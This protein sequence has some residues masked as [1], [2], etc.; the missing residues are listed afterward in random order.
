[1]YAKARRAE[2]KGFTGIDD[3]YEPP[4][5]PEITLDTVA[6]T[7]QENTR[8]I[9][10]YLVEQGFLKEDVAAGSDGREANGGAMYKIV[11]Q[12]PQGGQASPELH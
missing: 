12:G 5:Q 2:I 11:S 6:R 10:Q 7:S 3:A 9:L 4:L 1:M 8:V